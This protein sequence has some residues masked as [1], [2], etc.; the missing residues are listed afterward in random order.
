MNNLIDMEKIIKGLKDERKKTLARLNEINR[1]IKVMETASKISKK[2]GNVDIDE[3]PEIS[4]HQNLINSL[5]YQRRRNKI[6]QLGAVGILAERIGN[7]NK[8][9]KLNEAKKIM[10]SAGFFKTPRNASNILYT[11][12]D[13]SKKFEKI[14]PGIYRLLGDETTNT[15]NGFKTDDFVYAAENEEPTDKD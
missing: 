1:E 7:G 5:K 13:R 4:P 15:E 6:T 12:I 2:V 14:E 3:T 11:I 10:V 9:F 8:V